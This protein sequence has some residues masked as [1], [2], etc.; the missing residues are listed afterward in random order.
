MA[1]QCD[2]FN[3]V[4]KA[5]WGNYVNKGDINYLKAGIA[6][7]REITRTLDY[8]FLIKDSYLLLSNMAYFNPIH[9]KMPKMIHTSTDCGKVGLNVGILYYESF[10]PIGVKNGTQGLES[11]YKL[12]CMAEELANI[13][14]NVYVFSLLDVESNASFC[15]SGRNPQYLP[16]SH[17][18][19][20]DIIGPTSPGWVSSLD[21]LRVRP[22]GDYALDHMIVYK[23]PK[24]DRENFNNYA[25]TL[26]YWSDNMIV[27]NKYVP[28]SFEPTVI[29]CLGD[30][31]VDNLSSSYGK[32]KYI[33]GYNGTSVDLS[34]PIKRREEKRVSWNHNWG[35]GLDKLL[36]IWP[37]VKK[38]VP[39]A[40]LYV[41]YGRQT[42]GLLDEHNTKLIEIR[43]KVL[44]K[45]DVIST[46][47]IPY[48][49]SLEELKKDS[50]AAYPCNDSP[51]EPFCM[52]IVAAQQLG[53]IPLVRRV[54]ELKEIVSEQ[55]G[56]LLDMDEYKS[57]MI[58]YLKIS[59]D[60]LY[61]ERLR[62]RECT[63]KYTW[64]E[65]AKI[66][67]RNF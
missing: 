49:E 8:D 34:E 24:I 43:L 55:K 32:R 63:R 53:C 56:D 1:D 14:H 11:E 19:E 18:A 31:H 30:C 41:R 22:D 28:L 51:G 38:E 4:L 42:F 67:S 47:M 58:R 52:S 44:R 57:E 15:L 61:N 62:Y 3:K 2:E 60:E 36:D 27:G 64:K 40:I 26:S 25:P 7:T 33:K 37:E 66:Y 54:N 16:I 13:G 65:A 29:Y 48:E 50:I 9:G 20:S 6:M 10:N 17:N 5:A 45:Y 21:S 39:D 59:E 12:M 35:R 46:G 23:T